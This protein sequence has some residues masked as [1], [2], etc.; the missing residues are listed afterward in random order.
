MDAVDLYA[1]RD[2]GKGHGQR[3]G[4]AVACRLCPADAADKALARHAQQNS[5]TQPVKQRNPPQDRKI[6]RLCLAETNA[7][8]D[9]DM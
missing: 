7:R 1:L 8:V 5:T 4:K 3:S 9:H 2:P 6:M